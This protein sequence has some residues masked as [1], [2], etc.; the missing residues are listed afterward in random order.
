[1][2]HRILRRPTICWW[3]ARVPAARPIDPDRALLKRAAHVTA[4]CL[5]RWADHY[6]ATP[7]D[8]R[9]PRRAGPLPEDPEAREAFVDALFQW[10]DEVHPEGFAAE[11][12]LRAGD[13]W[14]LGAHDGF[15][16]PIHVRPDEFAILQHRL[17]GAD[18]PRDLYYPILEQ[19]PVIEPGEIHGGVVRQL[20]AVE[21]GD[22]HAAL[23]SPQAAGASLL[24]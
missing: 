24:G 4:R 17:A 1:M 12:S 19:R 22:G 23:T 2:Q 3:S 15:P 8:R 10:F 9:D 5:A 20:P 7:T 16:G 18:L 14:V 13:R 21:P 6:S 11:M